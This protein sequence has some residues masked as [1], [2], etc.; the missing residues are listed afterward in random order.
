MGYKLG[1]DLGTTWTAAAILRDGRST[2]VELSQHGTAVSSVVLIHDDL[3]LVGQAAEQRAIAE[4][5]RVARQFKRRMGDNTPMLLGG[6]P[7]S[8][9]AVTA[10]L[11]AWVVEQVSAQE[12]GPADHLVLTHPANWGEYKLDL[13][14]QAMALAGLTM[15]FDLIS[16][17][18]AAAIHYAS[19][20]RVE[21]GTI[22]GA[23]DLGGGTFD[24]SVL[25]KTDDGF[26]FLGQ[27]AGIERLGGIDFDEAVFQRVLSS[28]GVDLGSIDVENQALDNA[29]RRLRADCIVGKE[30]LSTDTD[31]SIPVML[32]T[33][34]TEVRLTRAEFESMIRSTLGD[35]IT[36]TERAFAS[37]GIEIDEIDR[38]LLVGGSSRIPVVAELVA[39]RFRRPLAVD[40][41]PK[42]AVALGAALS[43][44]N[45]D[46]SNRDASAAAAALH[47]SGQTEELAQQNVSSV[48]GGENQPDQQPVAASSM[49]DA[50]A[51]APAAPPAPAANRRV[52]LIVGLLATVIAASVVALLAL[53]GN[54]ADPAVIGQNAAVDAVD[55][56]QA[57]FV[58]AT[59]VVE[60]TVVPTIE[61]TVVPTIEPTIV[62]AIVV[63]PTVVPPPITLVVDGFF[64]GVRCVDVQGLCADITEVE[65]VSGELLINWDAN[66]VP[67]V[68]DR[69]HAHFFWSIYSPLQAGAG[70]GGD[71]EVSDAQP[72]LAG[73]Y[74]NAITSALRPPGAD[75][76]V[77]VANP[78][79][80]VRDAAVYQCWTYPET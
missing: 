1:I 31:T 26:E 73:T 63:V 59:V 40:A 23:Y 42:N 37:A 20:E 25:R 11:L 55:P 57:A 34:Q 28:V 38:I 72:H 36:V 43:A 14:R 21:P 5:S 76:C 44:M 77:T 27:P 50:E 45:H 35:T 75:I 70:G 51:A 58:T 16:E 52:L 74:G 47:V 79:H 9:E 10:R 48:D 62:P 41:H 24:A 71:W 61:P 33:I 13:L 69:N 60:P 4:P 2:M 54:D 18:E 3:I 7:Y 46:E 8:A 19:K 6:S 66:F 12:G 80:T 32:P 53:T 78:D 65:L 39:T 49:S 22:I 15:S 17:P 29:L 67:N 64:E 56:T 30:I 68:N